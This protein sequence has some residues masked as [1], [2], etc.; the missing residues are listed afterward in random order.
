LTYNPRTTGSVACAGS[1]TLRPGTWRASPAV[2]RWARSC[3]WRGGVAPA[4]WQAARKRSASVTRAQRARNRAVA[5][6][7]PSPAVERRG[8]PHGRQGC[9]MGHDYIP[10]T[11]SEGETTSAA[12]RRAVATPHARELRPD[13]RDRRLS[14]CTR[15]SH[16]GAA[17]DHRFPTGRRGLDV[18]D[19]VR[20]AGCTRA[21]FA[22]P[23]RALRRALL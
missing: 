1:S 23:S 8:S 20:T 2:N 13:R 12:A 5:V 15:N 10:R 19:H 17:A 3:E 7:T 14:D 9:L 22:A 21:R 11:A 18:L 16:Q 4:S 6:P